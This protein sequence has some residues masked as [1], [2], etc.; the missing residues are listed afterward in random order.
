MD[1]VAGRQGRENI[2]VRYCVDTDE[3][4]R[5]G[6]GQVTARSRLAAGKWPFG[7]W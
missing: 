6:N 1:K 5:P 7:S 4:C 3:P 2:T